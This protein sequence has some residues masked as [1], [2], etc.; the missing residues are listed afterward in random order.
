MVIAEECVS[1]VFHVNFVYLQLGL[2]RV[3]VLGIVDDELEYVLHKNATFLRVLFGLGQ[4]GIREHLR[5]VQLV[6]LSLVEEVAVQL[7]KA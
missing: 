1:Q 6:N 5:F 4:T 7:I 3:E 2:E